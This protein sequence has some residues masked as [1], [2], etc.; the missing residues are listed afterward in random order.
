MA[1]HPHLI[2]YALALDRF[3]LH[4]PPPDR[5]ND[6]VEKWQ[7]VAGSGAFFEHPYTGGSGWFW[8][9]DRPGSSSEIG[10]RTGIATVTGRRQGPDLT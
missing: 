7:E 2:S 4:G 10:H 9:G 5:R 6:R 3:A 8:D 1:G